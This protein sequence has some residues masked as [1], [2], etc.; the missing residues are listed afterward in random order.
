MEAVDEVE[1]K[2]RVRQAADIGSR[3]QWCFEIV[4]LGGCYLSSDVLVKA[5]TMP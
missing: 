4:V 3:V 2:C 5:N 1:I